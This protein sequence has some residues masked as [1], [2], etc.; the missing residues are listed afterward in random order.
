MHMCA[1]AQIDLFV[2]I[3]TTVHNFHCEHIF[4]GSCRCG[5]HYPNQTID[6]NPA[7]YRTYC[8]DRA[9]RCTD[10]AWISVTRNKYSSVCTLC[11]AFAQLC[12]WRTSEPISRCCRQHRE[13]YVIATR[14]TGRDGLHLSGAGRCANV[15]DVKIFITPT[16]RVGVAK[17]VAVW[18]TSAGIWPGSSVDQSTSLRNWVSGVRIPPGSPLFVLDG[19]P[20]H[21]SLHIEVCR[22]PIRFDRAAVGVPM[23]GHRRATGATQGG[24]CLF[25]LKNDTWHGK[26]AMS[27]VE[28]L[29]GHVATPSIHHV[30]ATAIFLICAFSVLKR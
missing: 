10:T 29:W 18:Y 4:G 15:S 12:G 16:G 23:G 22:V 30:A 25:V 8:K 3:T 9:G 27:L 2:R 28:A 24:V 20:G 11:Q 6:F 14:Q 26:G 19:I 21:G 7:L 5:R 13:P 1:A 17:L